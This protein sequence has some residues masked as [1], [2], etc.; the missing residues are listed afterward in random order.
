MLLTIAD[1][2]ILTI[3]RID[4][5]YHSYHRL[6]LLTWP[7]FRGRE[8]VS[9]NTAQEVL[10]GQNHTI[11][12]HTSWGQEMCF[13]PS[14]PRLNNYLRSSFTRE[15]WSQ[16]GY[17]I[18]KFCHWPTF[19]TSGNGLIRNKW[20]QEWFLLPHCTKCSVYMLKGTLLM[21]LLIEYLGLL[22]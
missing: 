5:K 17:L 16:I 22:R 14:P 3:L 8:D 2:D 9:N 21:G 18:C 11:L 12:L 1:S 15:N 7:E 19:Q 20:R 4:S 6:H 10:T 13:S